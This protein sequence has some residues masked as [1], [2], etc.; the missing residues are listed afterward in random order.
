MLFR[1]IL[2]G[3]PL[4]QAL[5]VTPHDSHGHDHIHEVRR[6]LPDSWYQPEGHPIHD[7]FKRDT[8]DGADYPAVGSPAWSAGY[9]TGAPDTTNLPAAWV[10][11]LNAAVAAG[12]IPSIP[13]TTNTPGTN[14]VY[15]TGIDPSSPSVCSATYKCRIPGDIWDSPDGVFASS[16]DDGPSP[17][18][19][20]L[21]QFLGGNNDTT[22]HF[23]IGINIIY[24]PSQFLTALNAG[25]DIG[26]HTWTHPY[27]TTQS[28]LDL[29]GQFGYTIQLIHDSSGGRVPRYWRPPYGDSDMR[30]R[31]IALEVFGLETVIWNQDTDDWDGT[32][33]SIQAA[34]TR[35]LAMPK[36]PGL[37]VLEHEIASTTV[38]GFMTAYPM[39][40]SN[41]WKFMSLAKAIADGRTYQNAEGS[42]SDDVE[43]AGILVES[44]STSTALPT[45]TLALV[46]TSIA[47]S[48]TSVTSATSAA[49]NLS[50]TPEI[51]Q[52]SAA[53][54][55]GGN[56]KQLA[57]LS[58]L[59]SVL[60]FSHLLL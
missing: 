31:A 28:N 58:L 53:I 57:S 54:L 32:P 43:S 49:N 1:S 8:D 55:H 27:M 59:S 2:L 48:N 44:T 17:L 24:Y 18:T 46:A 3:L 14:P 23:M 21:V 13:P 39:I 4:V 20:S 12:K 26:V 60:V 41:G 6:S 34:M 36:S 45:T 5:I 9:P 52:I 47:Q 11:A 40:K 56:L 50:P 25:H 15:P 29:L 30:V 10:A 37:I 7:L 33:D 35:F 19:P 16:F 22:T 51:S 38:N 42:L